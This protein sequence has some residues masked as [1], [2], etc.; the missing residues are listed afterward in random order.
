MSNWQ[1]IQIIQ[2]YAIKWLNF[3]ENQTDKC[4]FQ[5][6]VGGNVVYLAIFVDDGILAKTRSVL[7]SVINSLRQY[8]EITLGDAVF[9]GL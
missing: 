7:D 6:V 5:G 4:V 3:V 9:V 8:F 2:I 1:I